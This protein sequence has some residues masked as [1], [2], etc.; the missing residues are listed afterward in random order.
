[1]KLDD[2]KSK[3]HS[4][5][6]GA[7]FL[8]NNWKEIVFSGMGIGAGISAA[9]TNSNDLDAI[10]ADKNLPAQ[11]ISEP[12]STRICVPADGVKATNKYDMFVGDTLQILSKILTENHAY[13]IFTRDSDG[14]IRYIGNGKFV[15]DKEGEF[16]GVL[17]SYN[18]NGSKNSAAVFSINSKDIPVKVEIE[19]IIDTIESDPIVKA[20]FENIDTSYIVVDGNRVEVYARGQDC[21]SL[22]DSAVQTL[23]KLPYGWGLRAS[24]SQTFSGMVEPTVGAQ[25]VGKKGHGFY[26]DIGGMIQNS[27]ESTL[28]KIES[29]GGDAYFKFWRNANQ[30]DIVLDISAGYTV[31][32]ANGRLQVD[33]GPGVEV[34]NSKTKGTG[35]NQV[36]DPNSE[37]YQNGMPT[38]EKTTDI[39]DKRNQHTIYGKI[40]PKLR[41]FNNNK[42]SGYLQ[43]PLKYAGG[44]DV[45]VAAGFVYQFNKHGGKK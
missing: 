15:A 10:I 32:I 1:M 17:Q 37:E 2:I 31:S 13:K 24:A 7:K 8:R 35:Y 43:F 12:D 9:G 27:D 21:D 6:D 19:R 33:A 16:R 42:G 39:D 34:F 3:Y 14:S 40:N 23:S 30:R 26:V 41:I 28:P 5:I 38:K 44:K 18:N 25:F 29:A 36:W 22:S 4:L 20:I 45:R 11:E